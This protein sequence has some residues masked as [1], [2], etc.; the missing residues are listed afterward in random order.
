MHLAFFI[1][2]LQINTEEEF[3]KPLIKEGKGE[4]KKEEV[5]KDLL[6]I[7][8]AKKEKKEVKEVKSWKE[9]KENE[10]MIFE[11]LKFG[12]LLVFVALFI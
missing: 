6:R 8:N 7:L 2:M 1:T 5:N 4:E 10:V 12:H 11:V 9:I 3:L